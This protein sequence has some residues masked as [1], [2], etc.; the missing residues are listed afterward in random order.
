M[1]IIISFSELGIFSFHFHFH[2]FKFGSILQDV[3]M[4][5]TFR[6]VILSIS[7]GSLSTGYIDDDND[8]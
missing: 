3:L 4:I 7:L 8:D 2:I 6:H 1:M 5:T